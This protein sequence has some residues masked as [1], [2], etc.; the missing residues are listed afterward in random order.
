MTATSSKIH[1]LLITM[2]AECLWWSVHGKIGRQFVQH[3][4]SKYI[5]SEDLSMM[6]VNH[7]HPI[8]V[9]NIY[10]LNS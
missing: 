5:I 4:S 6:I 1:W 2:L 10:D 9:P 3:G 8:L 7:N